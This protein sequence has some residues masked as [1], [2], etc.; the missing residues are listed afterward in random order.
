MKLTRLF[1][2]FFNSEKTGGIVLIACTVVSMALANSGFQNHYTGF[3]ET[4]F[5]DHSLTH[6]IN[7]GLMSIFFLLI[8]LELER[9]IYY[10][11]LSDLKTASFPI[12]AAIGGVLVPAGVYLL[13][14]QGTA[15]QDGAGIPM[16]TDIAFSIGMLAL[17]GSRV[18]V[19][20]KVFIT[21][22]AVIDDLC[23]II[24]IA[25]FYSS[26]LSLL[27]MGIA[28]AIMLLMFVLNRL[29]VHH[30][31]P[32]LVLG[33]GLWYCM[34]HSGIH[35]T[36]AGVLVAF[37]IPFGDGGEKS[38][39]YILQNF[40]HK[41][42]AF[43]II[44]L[45]A[46]ANTAIHFE[47]GWW[48]GLQSS[49]SI[50]I[51]LGLVLGKPIGILLFAFCAVMVGLSKLPSGLQW[52]HIAGVGMLAG[53]GFTMSIFI[54]MLAFDN[55]LHIASAKIAIIAA[56]LIAAIGGLLVLKIILK[57]IPGEVTTEEA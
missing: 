54:T 5:N 51:I 17:L 24:V 36:L 46:L 55:P 1:S 11:E 21:A 8:G 45:F 52:K 9:E 12:I 2:E 33:V 20:L 41:P 38:P 4:T 40:L 23:A 39:S 25:I 28:A 19:N 16:A 44:P 30:L 56:S 26:G 15:Y 43:I 34:L 42:V 37:V 50:G 27:Y 35:A 22:L 29:K 3:W 13:I 31:W 49:G 14:N 10:G 53:I 57:K 18:P 7:D 32:Y 6:W 47:P 48:A